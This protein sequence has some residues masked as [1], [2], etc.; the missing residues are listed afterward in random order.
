MTFGS[1]LHQ[2]RVAH[3]LSRAVFAGQLGTS[4]THLGE[5]ETMRQPPSYAEVQRIAAILQLPPDVL[6]AQ[7]G[8]VHSD[9]RPSV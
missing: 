7:A 9:R 1:Y 5:L 2:Q 8:Y 6:L 3:N 4:L